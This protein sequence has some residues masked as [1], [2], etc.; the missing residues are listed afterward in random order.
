[1]AYHGCDYFTEW[2]IGRFSGSSCSNKFA[3]MLN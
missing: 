3:K 2:I 1:M